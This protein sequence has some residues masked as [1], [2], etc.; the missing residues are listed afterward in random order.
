MRKILFFFCT[1]IL[2]LGNASLVAKEEEIVFKADLIVEAKLDSF[3][4]IYI[5][6]GDSRFKK[7]RA[8]FGTTQRSRI[9]S[10][11]LIKENRSF[12]NNE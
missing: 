3:G 9:D 12:E 7:F 8:S 1:L 2:I 11:K 5:E 6:P 4:N 10:K